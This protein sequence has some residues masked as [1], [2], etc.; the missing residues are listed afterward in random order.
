MLLTRIP[1]CVTLS[2]DLDW[3]RVLREGCS[4]QHARAHAHTYIYIYIVLSNTTL[5]HTCSLVGP[6]HGTIS[7]SSISHCFG[8]L[9]IRWDSSSRF[10]LPSLIY[11]SFLKKKKKPVWGQPRFSMV[12]PL[13][14]LAKLKPELSWRKDFMAWVKLDSHGLM[15]NMTMV[16][17]VKATQISS[18]IAID[19]EFQQQCS[20]HNHS[21][22]QQKFCHQSLQVKRI[23]LPGGPT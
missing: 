22:N 21:C 18:M 6:P 20:A 9:W 2:F 8:F 17:I 16:W 1:N 10:C 23:C 4:N 5:Q 13:R 11:N 15:M 14:D 3:L 12:C 19:F 7:V